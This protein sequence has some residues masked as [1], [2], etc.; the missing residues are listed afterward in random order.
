MP[1]KAEPT[2]KQDKVQDQQAAMTT[3][4]AERERDAATRAAEEGALITSR[5]KV[6]ADPEGDIDQRMQALLEDHQR[7]GAR[8]K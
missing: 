7:M 6:K 1:K 8:P 5:P 4:R 3:F 2:D